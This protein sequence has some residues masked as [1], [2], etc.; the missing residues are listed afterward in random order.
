[1]DYDVIVV[2]GRV[3]GS[4][5]SSYA[6]KNGSNVLMIEKHQEIGTPVHCAGGVSDSFFKTMNIKPSSEYTLCRVEGGKIYSPDGNFISSKDKILKGHILERKIFDKNLAIR[7]ANEGVDIML[8][9]TVTGLLTE[10]GQVKGVVAKHLGKKIEISS[11]VVIAADGIESQVAKLYGLDTNFNP[12]NVCSCAQMEMVGLDVDTEMLEF[13][14]GEKIAPRGYVWVFPK[15]EN[16]ANVGLGIRNS[17]KTAHEYLKTF[18]KKIG[19]T[20][21]ELNVGAVPLGG[22]IKKTYG[23]GILIVGDAAGQ[24]DPVTGGGIHVSA[25]C[26]KIAGTVAADAVQKEEYSEKYLKK[27]EINWKNGIGRSL[28]KAIK[29]RNLFDKLNDEDINN[30]IKYAKNKD[31][32]SKLSILKL[33][34]EYP[35]L[36]K[37]LR[38]IL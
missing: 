23:N 11:K 35:E 6:S 8:K 4:I 31:I 2:G 12:Q 15:G 26:A 38:S 3:S 37:I 21:V 29:F 10:K 36:L 32:N 28:E 22:P 13:Y 34:K 19:G 20:P 25:E 9:T 1:M 30:L 16:R 18:L 14:F 17:E 24:V 27:Y 5:S 7:A 33:I